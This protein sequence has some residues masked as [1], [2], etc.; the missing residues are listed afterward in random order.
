MIAGGTWRRATGGNDDSRDDDD[1]KG[2]MYGIT[3]A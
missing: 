1:S 3:V 2:D